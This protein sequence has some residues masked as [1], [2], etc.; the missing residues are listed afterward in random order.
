[1]R[2]ED[3]ADPGHPFMF[4]CHILAHEDQGMMAQVVVVHPGEQAAAGGEG[5]RPGG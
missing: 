1:M 5:H 4:H 2:F 3:H